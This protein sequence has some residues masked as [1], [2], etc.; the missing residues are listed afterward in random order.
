M[1]W[2]PYLLFGLLLL[3][4]LAQL[5]VVVKSRRLTGQSAP[6][7]DD[8]LPEATAPRLLYFYSPHCGP[9]RTMTPVVEKL[10][11]RHTGVFKVDVGRYPEAARRFGIL[12]TPTVVQVSDGRITRVALGPQSPKRLEA[13]VQ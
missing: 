10:A 3:I 8:L 12:A 6:P 13:L 2:L 9:C 7:I 5:R 1:D 4:L 11:A